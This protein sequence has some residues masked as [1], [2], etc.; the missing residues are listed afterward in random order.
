M[1]SPKTGKPD[2]EAVLKVAVDLLSAE[3]AP[4][5]TCP[6]IVDPKLAGVFIHEAFGHLS[7]A[8]FIH[9][10]RQ[11]RDIMVLGREFGPRVP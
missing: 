4:G 11:M 2:A 9:E 1:K 6:V 8:D 5:T 3:P 10:N 7:E